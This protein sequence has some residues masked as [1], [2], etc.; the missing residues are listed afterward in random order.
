MVCRVS[1]CLV[2]AA[3]L[4]SSSEIYCCRVEVLGAGCI[5]QLLAGPPEASSLVHERLQHF[6]DSLLVGRI[7]LRG[8]GT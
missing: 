5:H 1:L 8:P 6:V 4:L 7:C 2:G 3:Q